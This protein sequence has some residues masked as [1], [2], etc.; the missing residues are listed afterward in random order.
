[1]IYPRM[2]ANLPSEIL[3]KFEYSTGPIKS[4][5]GISVVIPLRGNDRITN[6][7]Y[8]ITKMLQQNVEPLEIIISEEDNVPL[9]DN[10]PNFKRDSRVRY[11]FTKSDSKPFNKSRAV[12]AGVAASTYRFITMNDADIIIPK[13]YLYRICNILNEYESCFLGKEI[14]NMDYLRSGIVFRGSKRVDYFTGG[15]ISFVKEAFIKIGGM[16]EK[17]YDYGSEDCEFWTRLKALTNLHES[18]DCPLLHI[19]HRRKHFY[20]QNSELYS[21]TVAKTMEE[22]VAELSEDLKKHFENKA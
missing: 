13:D 17:F 7:C 8:C 4:V 12:N 15:S 18:R 19:N 10:L 3:K 1:M 21:K 6:L 2:L 20:S 22:R 11:I 16:N 14:Y 9:F 5:S